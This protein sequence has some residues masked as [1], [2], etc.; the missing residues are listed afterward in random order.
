MNKTPL[1]AAGLTAIVMAGGIGY[2]AS[3]QTRSDALPSLNAQAA[4]TATPDATPAAPVV[5]P[6]A[7]AEKDKLENNPAAGQTLAPLAT[8]PMVEVPDFSVLADRL[9]PT[10]VNVSTVQKEM[11]VD[12]QGIPGMPEGFPELPPGSPF[13]EFFKEFR[14]QQEQ[15][16][17]PRSQMPHP[18][19]LGSGFVIDADKG[20]I[21]TNNHVVKDA[22]EIKVIL[23]DDTTLDATLVGS[24]EKTDVAVLQVKTDKKLVAAPWGNSDEAKVGSWVLAIGN[25]Y[26]LGGTV[27]AGI[28]S[29]RQRDINAGPYDDFI[30]SDAAINRGNS[31]GPMFDAKGRVIGV[32]TAIFSPSGGSIGIGF[33]VPSN[34]A[35][36]ITDQLIKYGQ[37]RRGWIGVRIQT[38]TSDIAETLGMD[39][40]HGALVA[41][42]TAEG[43]SEKAGIKPGDVIVSFN[44]VEVRDMRALPRIVA[45]TDIE[46]AVPVTVWR[47]G[48]E[49][50]LTIT[51]GRLEEAE[52][53]GLL[54]EKPQAP[55]TQKPTAPSATSLDVLGIG[56]GT[57]DD[58]A[59]KK[60]G[61]KPD[62]TGVVIL[63]V[64]GRDASEKGLSEGD[65]ITEIDQAPVA[66]VSDLKTA[67]ETAAKEGRKSVL[68]FV[69]AGEDLRFVAVK[70]TAA[71]AE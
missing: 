23:H 35:K 21:V 52:K 24:D 19:A 66:S 9:L 44:K 37:T 8:P 4:E 39:K 51:T 57:I 32:N 27:T 17:G 54:E 28:V 47:G 64:T 42:V 48:K 12:L 3:A 33:A 10:V 6:S 29:A 34:L 18:S 63:N 40:A 58:A 30:Q 15:Q 62:T 61:I 50:A 36:P 7:V 69:S 1:I 16:G 56:V 41:S 26:G 60:Y 38:V 2:Y 55:G 53:G 65:V 46:T 43:P 59:R 5:T 20:Y 25:P 49:V 11:A 68:L 31:G 67:L 70:L 71:K 22:E 14:R 45:E 13:E